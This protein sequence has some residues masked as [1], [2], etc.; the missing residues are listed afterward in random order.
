MV[1]RVAERNLHLY[2]LLGELEGSKHALDNLHH[3]DELFLHLVRTAENMCIV[4]GKRAHSGETV[5]LARLL[6][7][8]DGAELSAAERQFLI[9]TWLAGVHL[10]VMGAVH[11]FEHVELIFF[12]RMDGLERVFAIMIPVAGSDVE[13]LRTDM[14]SDHFVIAIL[15][16]NAA[17]HILQ[18]QAEIGALR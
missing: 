3:L 9:R 14:R 1:V 7:A 15:L 6:I 12:G 8:I 5:K 17:E 18:A 4:L 16:L 13:I 2:V 10:T 11:R